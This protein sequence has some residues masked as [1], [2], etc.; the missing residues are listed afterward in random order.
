MEN[1]QTNVKNK[2]SLISLNYKENSR[3]TSWNNYSLLKH[4][5]RNEILVFRLNM[6]ILKILRCYFSSNH[7]I[8]WPCANESFGHLMDIVK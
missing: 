4:T 1:K 2:F 5:H 6:Q 7:I 8:N 3:R